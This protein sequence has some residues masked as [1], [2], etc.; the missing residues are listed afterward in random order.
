MSAMLRA[1]RS[2][3]GGNA[4]AAKTARDEACACAARVIVRWCARAALL[5]DDR[6]EKS[7]VDYAMLP[8]LHVTP[9][10]YY[11]RCDA[12]YATVRYVCL[13]RF[14]LFAVTFILPLAIAAAYDAARYAAMLV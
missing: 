12:D 7:A 2:R 14:S 13:M 8:R 10:F 9:P 3:Y 6:R 4:S 1:A 11:R 5:I